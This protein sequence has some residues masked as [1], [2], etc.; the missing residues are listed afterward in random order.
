MTCSTKPSRIDVAQALVLRPHH[1]NLIQGSNPNRSDTKRLG[2][3]IS[4][5]TPAVGP[6]ILPAVRARADDHRFEL[7][8]EPP[9]LPL[10][11]AVGVHAAF[12]R[13]RGRSEVKLPS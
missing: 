4:Y 1:V 5:V 6:S 10:E 3:A 8:E 13:E 7:M 11:E 2:F 9:S 12:L